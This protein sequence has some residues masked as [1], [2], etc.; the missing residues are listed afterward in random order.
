MRTF[1]KVVVVLIWTGIIT[2]GIAY[3]VGLLNQCT[4]LQAYIKVTNFVTAVIVL[5]IALVTL[6]A[7]IYLV[8][9]AINSFVVDNKRKKMR[10]LARN[11]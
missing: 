7:G 1:E 5:S 2:A 6:S 8:V 11:I 4:D 3:M 10:Q 9:D